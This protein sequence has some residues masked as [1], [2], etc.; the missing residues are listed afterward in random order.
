MSGSVGDA[1]DTSDPLAVAF[2]P[3]NTANLHYFIPH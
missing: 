1:G 3:G 2:F